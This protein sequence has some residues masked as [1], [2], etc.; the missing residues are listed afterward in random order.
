MSCS[1]AQQDAS[2]QQDSVVKGG[3][4]SA[5]HNWA[6]EGDEIRGVWMGIESW[7][8]EGTDFCENYSE[9]VFDIC[10]FFWY[11]RIDVILLKLL[12]Q[13]LVSLGQALMLISISTIII[14]PIA[15]GS[16]LVSDNRHLENKI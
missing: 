10:P 3:E 6:V 15:T 7:Y 1:S 14:T 4:S 16:S 11:G 5:G 8:F 12:R 9:F 13:P 2:A